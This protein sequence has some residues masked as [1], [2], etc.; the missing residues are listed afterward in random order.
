V[1]AAP[2]QHGLPEIKLKLS[3]E[4]GTRYREGGSGSSFATA[5]RCASRRWF[6]DRVPD[7]AARLILTVGAGR[8]ARVV[9]VALPRTYT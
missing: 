5:G 9:D 3:D 6:G 4:L 2:P 7:R 1:S 8:R